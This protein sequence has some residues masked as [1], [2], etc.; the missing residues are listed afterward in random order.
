[1]H[2]QECHAGASAAGLSGETGCP[3]RSRCFSVCVGKVGEEDGGVQMGHMEERGDH[4]V[5]G[6]GGGEGGVSGDD[7]DGVSDDDDRLAVRKVG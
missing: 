1:M 3:E 6:V 5:G 4:A 2:V 7:D